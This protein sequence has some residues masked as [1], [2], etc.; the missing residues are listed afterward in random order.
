MKDQGR[1]GIEN[2]VTLL[3]KGGCTLTSGW[4]TMHKWIDECVYGLTEYYGTNNIYELYAYLLIDIVKL[5][6]ENIILRDKEAMYYRDY[7]GRE[8]VYIR[9]GLVDQYEKF[10]LSHELGHALLHTDILQAAYSQGLLNKGK[11]EKE[12]HYFAVK[13]LDISI[14]PVECVGLTTEQIAGAMYVVEECLEYIAC[15]K[16]SEEL[17]GSKWVRA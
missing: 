8:V 12:A 10:I 16:Q 15:E 4:V 1:C 13:L 5:P 14:D 3:V 7:Q 2:I 11:L 17:E 6:K 9:E